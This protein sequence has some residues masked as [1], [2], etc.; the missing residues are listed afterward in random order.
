MAELLAKYFKPLFEYR[1]GDASTDALLDQ[2]LWFHREQKLKAECV[3]DKIKELNANKELDHD[4]AFLA[5]CIVLSFEKTINYSRLE[6]NDR[7]KLKALASKH[8]NPFSKY[9]SSLLVTF[10]IR[11]VNRE[12]RMMALDILKEEEST[13]EFFKIIKIF[14]NKNTEL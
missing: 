12:N 1:V 8:L 6:E 11:D 3:E 2:P 10:L 4:V 9:A 7:N 13:S 14:E 5:R